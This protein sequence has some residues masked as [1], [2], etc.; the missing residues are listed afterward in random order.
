MLN[1]R[2][3]E[4]FTRI[5]DKVKKLLNIQIN[6]LPAYHRQI[7]QDADDVLGCC[8]RFCDEEGNIVK[9]LITVD[10][11]YIRACLHNRNTNGSQFTRIHLLET[12][13]HEIAHLYV[14]EHGPEHDALT[15][16]FLNICLRSGIV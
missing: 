13:C 6:I 16:K 2:D 9:S 4:D 8:H 5:S 14:W 1:K 11:D 12:I 3:A 15:S 7:I 10:I